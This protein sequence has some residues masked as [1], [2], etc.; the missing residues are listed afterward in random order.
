MKEITYILRPTESNNIQNKRRSSSSSFNNNS[1][2]NSNFFKK[3]SFND[4][5]ISNDQSKP[6]SFSLNY[7]SQAQIERMKYYS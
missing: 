4:Y 5:L 1:N 2:S 3:Q 6:R 7:I